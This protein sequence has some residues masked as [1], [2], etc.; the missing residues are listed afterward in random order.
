[1]LSIVSVAS[2]MAVALPSGVHAPGSWYS[3]P[4]VMS[5]ALAPGVHATADH[6]LLVTVSPWNRSQSIAEKE[7]ALVSFLLITMKHKRQGI[8]EEQRSV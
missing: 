4:C 7:G 2:R 8:Y 6:P 5:V 3:R 1:M